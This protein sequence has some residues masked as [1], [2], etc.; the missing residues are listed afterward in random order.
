V[1]LPR[2]LL[3][4][5][6]AALLALP[7]LPAASGAYVLGVGDQS[8]ALFSDPFFLQLAPVRTRY[9]TP[10][11]SVFKDRAT[12]D[13]WMSAAH[14]AGMEVVVAFNPPATMACPNLGRARGCRPVGS[15]SFRAA[16]TAFHRRY[17]WVRIVQRC[18]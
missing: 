15:A 11:D 6:A 13:A 3:V 9:I 10:Y 2:P 7:L 16:F 17:P 12:L 5:L 18:A 4:A 1:R 14:D 8:P